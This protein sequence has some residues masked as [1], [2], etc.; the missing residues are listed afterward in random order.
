MF[1]KKIWKWCAS[2]LLSLVFVVSLLFWASH[3]IDYR[4]NDWWVMGKSREQIIE[5]YGE[6]DQFL[7]KEKDCVYYGIGHFR[8]Y[9]I[10]FN[11]DGYADSV[12]KVK[13][14]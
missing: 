6:F 9:V 13:E 11:E 8:Y 10:H 3:T 14:P 1:H 5:K 7:M 4:Y 2:I 12:F